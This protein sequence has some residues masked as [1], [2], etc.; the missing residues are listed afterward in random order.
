V[1]SVFV[2]PELVERHLGG[3]GFGPVCKASLFG[4]PLPLCSC[5]VI[6]VAASL[7]RHGASRG[8]TAGFLLSTPQTGVDSILVTFALL[9]PVFAVFRPIAAFVTGLIGGGLVDVFAARGSTPPTPDE[10]DDSAC[11]HCATKRSAMRR[12]WRHGFVTLP[13]DL[14]KPMLLGLLVAG[15]I[16]ALVP[17]RFFSE[18]IG[19]GLPAMLLMMLLGIPLYVCASASVP[20]AAAMI[21]KGVSPGAALVFL[22]TGPA[23]NAATIAIVWKMLGRRAAL[24]YLGTVAGTAL[25]FGLALDYLFA[26]SG[27]QVS[28]ACHWMLP[29]ALSTTLA[30]ALLLLL[31]YAL[32]PARKKG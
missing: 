26:V 20:I 12:V 13:R 28:Q 11:C 23:T 29:P 21:L 5:S 10:A 1:L 2:S 19:T 7:H 25:G 18:K 4:V 17:D 32:L 31:G 27:V 3:R 22:M 15:G 9:G 16:A 24:I 8:A 14:A 30:V 6:P